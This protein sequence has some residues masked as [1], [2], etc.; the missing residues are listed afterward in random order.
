MYV[1]DCGGLVGRG[2]VFREKAQLSIIRAV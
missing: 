1:F 2:V